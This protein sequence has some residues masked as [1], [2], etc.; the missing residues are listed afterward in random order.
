MLLPEWPWQYWIGC[1]K[2]SKGF[3]RG[4]PLCQR[5]F[6]VKILIF[7]DWMDID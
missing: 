2:G 7:L 1:T 4:L 3:D 6:L 5:V